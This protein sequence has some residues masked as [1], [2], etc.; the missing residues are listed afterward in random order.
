MTDAWK[1]LGWQFSLRKRMSL[2]YL[3]KNK[4]R[5]RGQLGVIETKVT[6][7]GKIVPYICCLPSSNISVKKDFDTDVLF[8]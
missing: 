5:E 8:N 1:L 7:P 4:E 2:I 6:T 3:V